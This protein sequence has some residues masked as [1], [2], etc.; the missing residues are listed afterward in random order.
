MNTIIKTITFSGMAALLLGLVALPGASVYAAGDA[1]TDTNTAE[2]DPADASKVG[3]RSGLK[4]TKT[5]DQKANLGNVIEQVT[6]VLLF[7]IGAISVIMIIIGGIKY[8]ISN[9]DSGAITSAKNTI[10]YA[11]IGLVVALLA[12][13]IVKFVLDSFTANPGNGTAQ[14]KTN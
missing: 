10:F 14:M 13:A 12:Y 4:C 5:S 1:D 3:V 6:N 9:G 2:C 7:I 8:T 11:V